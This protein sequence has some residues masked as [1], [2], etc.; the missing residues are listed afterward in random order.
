M[1]VRLQWL[2][3]KMMKNKKEDQDDQKV[4]KNK[5][6]EKE[7]DLLNFIQ[8]GKKVSGKVMH[9]PQHKKISHFGGEEEGINSKE[10]NILREESGKES[11]ND[12]LEDDLIDLSDYN[13]TSVEKVAQVS[14]NS[15][16]QKSVYENDGNNNSEKVFEI[17]EGNQTN[18]LS[19]NALQFK[20][21]LLEQTQNNLFSEYELIKD[22]WRWARGKIEE[23]EADLE[24]CKKERDKEK[25][26]WTSEK[27]ALK[28]KILVL[29]GTYIN[30][31]NENKNINDRI[32]KVINNNDKIDNV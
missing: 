3:S 25:A 23:L 6:K 26:L 16:V 13:D 19:L 9:S 17:E 7:G 2:M 4:Q 14:E 31:E 22:E 12:N 24:Q 18:N 5:K 1:K 15:S 10:D 11:S 29:E 20:I 8:F 32:D 27:K 21:K 30:L 28:E